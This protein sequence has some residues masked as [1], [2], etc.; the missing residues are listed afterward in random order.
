MAAASS[1]YFDAVRHQSRHPEGGMIC[2]AGS[3]RVSTGIAHQSEWPR[4]RTERPIG[5]E[6][7]GASGCLREDP[8]RSELRSSDIRAPDR[9]VQIEVVRLSTIGSFEL[10]LPRQ[11]L[12]GIHCK[13]AF[14]HSRFS[15][16]RENTRATYMLLDTRRMLRIM[17]ETDT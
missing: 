16:R 3:V 17:V 14:R 2:V 1:K 5:S 13:S 15:L 9:P 7:A 6:F 10:C 11:L 12:R 8:G 4:T